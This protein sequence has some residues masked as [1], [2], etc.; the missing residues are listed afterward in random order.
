MSLFAI[1]SWRGPSAAAVIVFTG[2]T[3]LSILAA[4]LRFGWVYPCTLIG[5]LIAILPPRIGSGPA[6]VQMEEE[7]RWIVFCVS[8][9]IL[10]GLIIDGA[11]TDYT[12]DRKV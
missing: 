10:L 1:Y 7:V 2:L 12:R 11:I 4:V 8:G 5:L 6:D 9:G 3:A